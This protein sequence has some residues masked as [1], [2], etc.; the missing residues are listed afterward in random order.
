MRWW[1]ILLLVP[2]AGCL[3]SDPGSV[4]EDPVPPPPAE[5]VLAYGAP[6]DL[7]CP[8]QNPVQGVVH[9]G[10]GGFG[11]PVIEVAGDG[12][13]WASA[14]C[15]I[16]RS[17]PIW[18]SRDGGESFQPFPFAEGTGATRDAFGIEGDFA[19][20]D[21]GNVY[22]FDISAVTSYFTKFAPDGSH[23]HT[24]ADPFPP[25]VDR[26]WVRAG[27]EDEVWVFYNT[28]SATRLYRSADGGLTWELLEGASF[29]CPLMTVGQGPARDRLFVA[30][31]P[32][33]PRLWVSE[34]GGRTWADPV[35]LPRPDG[36]FPDGRRTEF[37][38]PPVADAGGTVYVPLV[39][40]VPGSDA[41]GLYLDTV[42]PDGTARGPFEVR[43]EGLNTL[44]WPAAGDAGRVALAWYGADG[45]DPDGATWHLHAAAALDADGDTPSF[46]VVR[47]D[48]EPVL[49]GAMG[50]ELGDFLQSDIGPDGRHYIVYAQRDGAL[51][52]RVVV[53]EGVDFGAGVPANGPSDG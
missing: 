4:P 36:P 31:C 27:A 25:L 23:V 22:F 30:G 10:C 47:A 5:A 18:T 39:H 46:Q 13:V 28:G 20:D 44:P 17:P 40:A 48:P 33:D 6:V 42:G 11:E 38:M 8:E 45:E 29:P 26:P 34:D 53:S 16:G 21:A 9:Q 41:T 2:L 1:P 24:K 49:Q 43:T 37:L 7:R 15:C 35:R 12:T 52:N 3:T 19:V 14:T 32:D 51:V 50:R